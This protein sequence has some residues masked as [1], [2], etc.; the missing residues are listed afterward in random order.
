MTWQDLLDDTRK[1]LNDPSRVA[2]PDA[3]LLARV[4]VTR[5][6]LYGMHPE[7]FCVS[8]VVVAIPSDPSE[9][10]LTSAIDFD[11]S[12]ALAVINHV[13]WQCFMDDTDERQNVQQAQL[14]YDVWQ[15]K[16]EP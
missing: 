3:D 10:S 11:T 7:A 4:N 9:S 13:Q 2:W 14:H 5:R 15:R 1:G 12:W 16:V 6:E 8:S